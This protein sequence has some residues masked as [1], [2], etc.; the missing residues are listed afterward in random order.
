MF[1][2]MRDM[3]QVTGVLRVLFTGERKIR[4]PD[5]NSHLAPNGYPADLPGLKADFREGID[6]A[7]FSR[8]RELGLFHNDLVDTTVVADI[9]AENSNL[10]WQLR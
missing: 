9:Q 6:D 2:L 8:F 1:V 3:G 10:F 7:A 5:F 4:R